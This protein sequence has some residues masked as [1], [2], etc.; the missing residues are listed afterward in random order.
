MKDAELKRLGIHKAERS[1]EVPRMVL[2]IHGLEKE[3]KTTFGFTMPDPLGVITDDPMTNAIVQK[4]LAKGREIYIKEFP[5]VESQDEAKPIW[6]EYQRVYTAMLANM[7]SL[8]VD[9]DTGGWQLQRM[10]EYGKLS[11]VPPNLYITANARKSKLIREANDSNCNVCFIYKVKKV[12]VK[13]KKDKMGQWNGEWERDGFNQSGFLLQANLRAF[14]EP[15]ENGL[16][17][18]ERFK[19]EVINCN[20]NAEMDGEILEYPLNNFAALAV[21]VFPESDPEEWE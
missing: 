11:Q 13:T 8:L 1:I 4:E 5:N 12:Y 10:A 18:E 17:V 20:N 9:T 3:G 16:S 19:L 6:K 21:E 7:R 2:G 14:K 15:P